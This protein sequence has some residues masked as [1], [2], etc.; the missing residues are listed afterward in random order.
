MNKEVMVKN[1]KLALLLEYLLV[2]LI[3][4]LVASC[5]MFFQLKNKV[6]INGDDTVFHDNRFYEILQQIKTNNSSYF[7]MNWSFAQ[8]G[9]IV[10]A[11][12]GPLF[13][14]FMSFLLLLSGTWFKFQ[15]L[16]NYLLFL[17]G[18]IGMYYFAKRIKASKLA[19]I[20][21]MILFLVT[22]YM[23]Y[24]IPG[25]TFNSWGAALMP[26]VLIQGVKMIQSEKEQINWL[27]LGLTMAVVAQVHMLSIIFSI[28]ALI[29]FF[30]YGLIISKDK[31]ELL[32]NTIKAILL[33]FVLTSNIWGSLCF[34]A[35]TNHL[36][37]TAPFNVGYYA[38]HIGVGTNKDILRVTLYLIIAQLFYV[39]WTHSKNKINVFITLEG[40]SFLFLSSQLIPWNL[41]TNHFQFIATNLQFPNRFTVIAYPLIFGGIALS[42]T[43]FEREWQSKKIIGFLGFLA[44]LVVIIFSLKGNTQRIK[45]KTTE[46]MQTSYIVNWSK[47]KNLNLL[48]SNLPIYPLEYLPLHGKSTVLEQKK[49]IVNNLV[50]PNKIKKQVLSQGRLKIMWQ[51]DKKQ[52][53][54]LLPIVMYHQSKLEVNGKNKGQIK[55][56]NAIGM[57]VVKNKVGENEAVLT[58]V[59]PHWFTVLLIL[60]L[61]SW[62]VIIIFASYQVIR[63]CLEKPNLLTDKR[64]KS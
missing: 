32:V 55:H 50:A 31:K 15:I 1:K 64:V 13:G 14:Y 5:I 10:N 35:L 16:Q 53:T 57:P 24:W 49:L 30:I 38:L 39:L 19:A 23:A 11:V 3:I 2:I 25:G 29:P 8:T 62:V 18:G 56:Y 26:Y 47:D 61:I 51:A 6:W 40:I 52:K 59:T 48:L 60:N 7:Q 45:Q 36:S 4:L 63:F 41:I 28:C 22:G 21:G 43:N 44:V 58:F 46:M 12:Y 27:E 42:L 17:L 9:R 34:L 33:F 54:S 20:L 37:S